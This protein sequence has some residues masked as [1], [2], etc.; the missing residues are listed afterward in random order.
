MPSR[1]GGAATALVSAFLL[2]HVAVSATFAGEVEF[3]LV[4]APVGQAG[5]YFDL[6]MEPGQTRQL[7]VAIGNDGT[8]GVAARTYA[9]DVFTITN[10]GYG[11]RLRDAPRTGATTWLTYATAV[12]DLARGAACHAGTDGHGPRGRGARRVHQQPGGRERCLDPRARER[13]VSTRSC[14]RPSPW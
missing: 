8:A 11:G 5:P 12:I 13:S 2:A 10:G 6:T 1:R 9:T 7:Q 4:L 14:G 3:K